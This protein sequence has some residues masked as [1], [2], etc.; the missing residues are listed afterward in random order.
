MHK[1]DIIWIFGLY[2][3]AIGAGVLFLPINAGI[4]GLLPVVL[5][6]IIAFPMIFFSHFGLTNF[7]LSGSKPNAGITDVVEEHFGR[8][9]GNFITILYFFSIYPILLIYGVSIT[10]NVENFIVELLGYNAPPRWL[11]AFI[12][13]ACIMAVVSFGENYIVK[14]ISILVF[15]FIIVLIIFSLYMIPH[16][17]SASLKTLSLSNIALNY[18]ENWKCIFLTIWL[19]IPVMIFSFNH[20]SIISEF[21]IY[22]REKYGDQASKKSS[23][24]LASA[25]ILMVLTVMFFVFSCVFTLSPYDLVKAKEININILDY[26][27]RYFDKPF[28]KYATSL[29]AFVAIIKSFLGHYLGAREGFNSLINCAYRYKNKTIDI[30]KLNKVTAIFML[31]TTWLVSTLN[32]GVLK[33][34]ESLCGPII[35]ILLFIMPIYARIKIQSINKYSG[36]VSNIFILII[37]IIAISSTI[38]KLFL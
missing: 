4:S 16:W 29:I 9:I 26:L 12:L 13:V 21:S 18:S 8:S 7:I 5:M 15:P 30:K 28:I 20:L 14:I 3:T 37:A 11:L 33:I 19:T 27:S 24:T 38:Y 32:P 17:N 6:A 22:N 25:H 31:I 34:I 2:G 1:S 35:A 10:N 36:Y 23:R